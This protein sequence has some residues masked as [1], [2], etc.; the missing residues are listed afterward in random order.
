MFLLLSSSY[1]PNV[2]ILVSELFFDLTSKIENH[3]FVLSNSGL[4]IQTT[5][6]QIGCFPSK[7]YE[8]CK[9]NRRA[10]SYLKWRREREVS[11]AFSYPGKE[12]AEERVT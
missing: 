9:L 7:I 3:Q 5:F 8:C 10:L 11:G 12:L 2:N 6:I 1:S 4:G